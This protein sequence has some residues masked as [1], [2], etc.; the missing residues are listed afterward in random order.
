MYLLTHLHLQSCMCTVLIA[1]R[2]K[3]WNWFY[4]A[5]EKYG[6]EM[7]GGNQE[8]LEE[9]KQPQLV[10]TASSWSRERDDHTEWRLDTQGFY[11][12]LCSVLHLRTEEHQTS[13]SWVESGVFRCFCRVRWLRFPFR[14]S[15]RTG[16]CV[17]FASLKISFSGPWS[18]L[19]VSCR[20]SRWFSHLQ[21]KS[22][23]NGGGNLAKPPVAWQKLLMHVPL[24]SA[25]L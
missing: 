3:L 21:T 25:G 20:C 16:T 13:I 9:S 7:Q 14:N 15:S 5:N 10:R 19:L 6:N 22:V 17:W 23:G 8:N 12:F 4:S 2:V 1:G 18:V 11:I 24:V